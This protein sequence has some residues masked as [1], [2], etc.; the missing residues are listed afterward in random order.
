MAQHSEWKSSFIEVALRCLR[1]HSHG[2]RL[3]GLVSPFRQ[4]SCEQHDE[5]FHAADAR[6]EGSA[7]DENLQRGSHLGRNRLVYL[8]CHWPLHGWVKGAGWC[9]DAIE[10]R[11]FGEPLE[12]R[13]TPAINQ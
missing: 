1:H 5:G 4:S 13:A 8:E 7:I 9:P 3:A 6:R 12:T 2:E 10:V 11:R